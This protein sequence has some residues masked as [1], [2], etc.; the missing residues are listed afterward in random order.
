MPGLK[1]LEITRCP[2]VADISPI[3][4]LKDLQTFSLAA[5]GSA[6]LDD[7]SPLESLQKL[8]YLDLSRAIFLET[9]TSIASLIKLEYLNLNYCYNLKD[10]AAIEHFV[11]LKALHLKNCPINHE[12]RNMILQ[13]RLFEFTEP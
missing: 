11:R 8:T 12:Q 5:T 3:A 7:F 10:I 9:L 13:R 4:L 6:F 2:E 1:T